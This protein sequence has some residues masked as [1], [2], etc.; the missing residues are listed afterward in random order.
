MIYS[1]SLKGGVPILKGAARYQG[2]FEHLKTLFNRLTALEIEDLQGLDVLKGL[3]DTVRSHGMQLDGQL[4]ALLTNMLV[5]EQIAKDL[6]P[7][8]T[9]LTCA[10]PYFYAP[11]P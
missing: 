8:M 4:G 6:C 3:L 5:L 1:L 7:E 2:Y 11:Q 10:V 9:I